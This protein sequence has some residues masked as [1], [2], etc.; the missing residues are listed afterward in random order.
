MSGKGFI[1]NGQLDAETTNVPS[2]HNFINTHRR[3]ITET[4][5]SDRQGLVSKFFEEM[6]LTGSI[7]EKC[8]DLHNIPYNTDSSDNVVFNEIS[9]KN[10]HR[11]KVSSADEQHKE[12]CEL[13]NTNRIKEY[14]AMKKLFDSN[15]EEIELN[16]VRETKFVQLIV[17]TMR[18][19]MPALSEN[20]YTVN[21]NS[22]QSNLTLDVLQRNMSQVL[23]SEL[24]AFM[25]V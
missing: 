17:D 13:V 6:Y 2:F 25:K 9:V 20:Q 15:Q 10:C 5:L 7:S 3:D 1:Y 24:K 8:F 23:C 19:N 14:E 16:T 22:I 12:R 18:T 4:C 11:S 21:F